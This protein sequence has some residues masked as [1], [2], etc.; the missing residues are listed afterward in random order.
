MLSTQVPE[1][2]IILIGHKDG[3]GISNI[4]H[5]L[6]SAYHLKY[7]WTAN[8]TSEKDWVIDCTQT[9]ILHF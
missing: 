3:H 5:G 9:L 7:L 1:E 8:T 4:F 2:Q 6:T